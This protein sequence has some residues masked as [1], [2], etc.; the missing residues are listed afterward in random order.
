MSPKR[1][2]SAIEAS[3]PDSIGR[4]NISLTG[5]QHGVESLGRRSPTERLARSAVEGGGHGREV[6]GAMHAQVGALRE[7]LSQQPVGVLVRTRGK[8]PGRGELTRLR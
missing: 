7:V 2:K 1:T 4:R 6:V 3:T 5:S 8:R